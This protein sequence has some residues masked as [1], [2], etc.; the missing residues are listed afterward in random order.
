MKPIIKSGTRI[1]RPSEY[2][3]LRNSLKSKYQDKLDGLLLTGMR[4]VEAKR[5]LEHPEWYDGT[6]IHL[7]EFAQKKAKRKQLERWIRLSDLGRMIIPRFLKCKLPSRTAWNQNMR[8]WGKN[9]GI[10]DEGMCA[11]TTRK[12]YESWLCFYFPEQIHKVFG[13]QG[14]D[15]ITS[16]QHYLSMPFVDEDKK[17]MRKWVEGWI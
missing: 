13:S 7:P 10:G 1:L 17:L 8:R 6:F 12:T 9:A 11:K 16:L 14:H 5:F 15:D 3:I 4:Y 2:E